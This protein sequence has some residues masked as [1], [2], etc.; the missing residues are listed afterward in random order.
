MGFHPLESTAELPVGDHTPILQP[1]DSASLCSNQVH[2]RPLANA[3][4]TPI[5]G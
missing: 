3:A 2:N 5:S 4:T 1:H